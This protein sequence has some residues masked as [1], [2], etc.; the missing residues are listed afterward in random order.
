MRSFMIFNIYQMLLGISCS[1]RQ[2]VGACGACGRAGKIVYFVGLETHEG[3]SQLGIRA[4]TWEDNIK[5]DLNEMILKT[6]N[7]SLGTSGALLWI[8][9]EL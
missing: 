3:K 8:C 4:C 6:V 2:M 5:I 9:N 1:G 7:Y